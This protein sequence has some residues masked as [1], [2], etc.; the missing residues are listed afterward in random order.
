MIFC[1]RLVLLK[2][3]YT[4]LYIVSTFGYSVFIF[5]FSIVW[6]FRM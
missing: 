6:S 2:K 3:N 4:D 1:I 5:S